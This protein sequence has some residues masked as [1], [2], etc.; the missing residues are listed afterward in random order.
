[1]MPTPRRT[2]RIS[3]GVIP[4]MMKPLIRFTLAEELTS[5]DATVTADILEQFGP[6][7]SHAITEDIT[8]RNYETSG[9][10]VYRWEGVSGAVG[11]AVWNETSEF[12]IIDL[13][14]P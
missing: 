1:M 14:C 8:V 3:R 12:V 11:L 13:E 4:L 5:A 2:E 7:A 9:S 6:G 10:G